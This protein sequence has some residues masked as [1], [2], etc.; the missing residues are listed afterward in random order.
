M[1]NENKNVSAKEIH[2]FWS[3]KEIFAKVAAKYAKS[4]E[5]IERAKLLHKVAKETNAKTFVE[6]MQG[7]LEDFVVKLTNQEMAL[8]KG[9]KV[10]WKDATIK[11]KGG[12]VE[13]GTTMEKTIVEKGVI[14][15]KIGFIP[16]KV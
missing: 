7:K 2:D 3:S 8:V 1:S 9:G 10:A 14:M 11:E 12:A 13:K 5:Q 6:F 4:P 16:E 15:E